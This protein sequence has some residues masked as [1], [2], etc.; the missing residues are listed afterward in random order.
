MVLREIIGYFVMLIP[1]LIIFGMIGKLGGWKLL[2]VTAGICLAVLGC[3]LG[4][5]YLI[6]G[7]F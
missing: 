2:G 1:V 5:V 6:E 3:L 7:G 4:G